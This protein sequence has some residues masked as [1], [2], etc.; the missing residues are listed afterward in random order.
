MNGEET[1]AILGKEDEKKKKVEEKE[2]KVKEKSEIGRTH[3]H[4]NT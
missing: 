2:E 1:P 3:K 4:R